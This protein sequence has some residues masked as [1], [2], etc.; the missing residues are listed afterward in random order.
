MAPTSSRI[1]NVLFLTASDPSSEN[2]DCNNLE[3]YYELQGH[4]CDVA[5]TWWKDPT[6]TS[7]KLCQYTHITF[8]TCD[9]YVDC[10][11]ALRI[12]IADVLAVAQ[13]R[14][15]QLRVLN[16][17]TRTLWNA[18][19]EYL[20]DL[21]RAG[22]RIAETMFLSV[23]QPVEY[24][25][26]ALATR[27]PGIPLVVKSSIA[28]SGLSTRLILDPCC[29]TTEDEAFLQEIARLP[30]GAVMIQEFLKEIQNDEYS[31]VYVG[32]RLQHAF[33]KVAKSQ[34]SKVNG[35][36][37]Q[38]IRILEISDI[39]KDATTLADKLLVHLEQM[40]AGSEQVS[41]ARVDGI[42]RVDGSFVLTGE[43]VFF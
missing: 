16:G 8:L 35:E 10:I 36:H 1:K 21:D 14:Q 19:K 43:Y 24:L 42:V 18:D 34:N 4:D 29:L 20:H 3:L 41:Y 30:N 31:L 25:K 23:T 12:W 6:L 28:A 39:P 27:T 11:Q 5:L 13:T 15:P 40:S 33:M 32:G 2:F 26:F 38:T 7:E 37:E 9:G 22:F 17:L